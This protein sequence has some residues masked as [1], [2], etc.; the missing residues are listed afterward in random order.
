MRRSLPL[1]LALSACGS[2]DPLCSP[3]LEKALV[4]QRVNDWYLHQE[5]LPSGLDPGA[6]AS[7]AELLDAATAAARAQG[8]DRGWSYL[9]PTAQAEAYFQRGESAGFGFGLLVR[10]AAPAQR[11]FVSQAFPGSPAAGAGFTRGD[12]ILAAGPS[13]GTLTPVAAAANDGTLGALV[14][15]K[16]GTAT[17]FSVLPLGGSVP[18]LRTMTPA[19]SFD[20]DPVPLHRVYPDGTGYVALRTFISP[21]EPLLRQ[22]FATLREAGVRR[23][24]VDVRYNGGGYISTAQLLASL[25][26]R[27]RT[28]E[29]M[30][31]QRFNARHGASNSFTPFTSEPEA[32][33]FERVAFVTTRASASASELVP[34][35]LDPYV[36][37]AFAGFEELREA[38]RPDHLRLG[39]LQG[40]ALPRLVRARQRGRGGRLLR[41][42]PRRLDARPAVRGGG[43]SHP[44]A[45][46]RGG[47]LHPGR[48]HLPAHRRLSFR[49]GSACAARRAYSEGDDGA[50][51][52]EGTRA[53]TRAARPAGALLKPTPLCLPHRRCAVPFTL[54]FLKVCL[55]SADH[56]EEVLTLQPGG[57]A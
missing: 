11:L 7:A 51:A 32:S 9:L 1:L 4:L 55:S 5:L 19:A 49:A 34:N 15:A 47:G 13:P 41:R 45:G 14:M 22:A 24:V 17:T 46:F 23:V 16:A 29:E 25:L 38:G 42:S 48:P 28:G 52:G 20:L 26:A 39:R 6:Y 36:D 8:L 12:E 50:R 56:R 57:P 43:R 54:L 2:G 30:F 3:V 35:A 31:E 40:R 53:H 27:D 21:A 18:L 37:I 10:G 44:R 33:A